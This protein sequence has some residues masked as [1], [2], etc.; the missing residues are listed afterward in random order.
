MGKQRSRL[1]LVTGQRGYPNPR[2]SA[3]PWRRSPPIVRRPS[4]S[5]SI[6]A[7][8]PIGGMAYG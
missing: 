4:R 8:Q 6:R 2:E 5:A 7:R 1:S 3:S